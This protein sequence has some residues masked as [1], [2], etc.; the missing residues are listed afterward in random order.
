M[1]VDEGEAV[2]GRTM[3]VGNIIIAVLTID[4]A[5]GECI[6]GP[7]I[8]SRGFV[9]VRESEDLMEEI[10]LIATEVVE[11]CTEG[12]SAN[13]TTIKTK[14]KNEVGSYLY[15]KTKRRPMILPIIMDV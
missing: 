1:V 14:I 3:P 6:S 2:F 11:K 12:T 13:W 4:K 5:S 8:I 15:S 9:Y 10:R 7:D